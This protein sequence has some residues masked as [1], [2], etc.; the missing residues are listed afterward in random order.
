MPE[1][2]REGPKTP[3][4]GVFNAIPHWVPYP[5]SMHR[6]LRIGGSRIRVFFATDGGSGDFT[7][8]DGMQ[9]LNQILNTLEVFC[10]HFFN[11]RW[12]FLEKIF[13]PPPQVFGCAVVGS[14]LF[15][16]QNLSMAR[17]I[18]HFP[19][20]FSATTTYGGWLIFG[21][22]CLGRTVHALAQHG[23]S[24][25]RLFKVCQVNC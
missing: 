24:A 23:T 11:G 8:A 20:F 13:G 10:R 2:S 19:S 22:S 5:K 21:S 1:V 15:H 14:G 18:Y 4:A 12:V 16:A 3:Y 25:L 6:L 7:E 17:K 9:I